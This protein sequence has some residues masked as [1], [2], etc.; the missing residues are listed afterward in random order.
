MTAFL[1]CT[2][3]HM[4]TSG[5][6]LYEFS[7]EKGSYCLRFYIKGSRVC[8]RYPETLDPE[9]PNSLNPYTLNPKAASIVS[10]KLD[11]EVTR[12]KEV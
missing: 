10:S 12:E 3:T 9:T 7:M 2:R 5:T 8:P 6:F 4:C 1:F 11:F